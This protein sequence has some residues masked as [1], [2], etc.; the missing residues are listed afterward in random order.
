MLLF[1]LLFVF[2]LL[3]LICV[4][5]FILF[6]FIVLLFVFIL[7][8]LILCYSLSLRLLGLICGVHLVRYDNY[9]TSGFLI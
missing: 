5:V 9:F 4:V 3:V 6:G 8:R 7:F 1:V 2:K